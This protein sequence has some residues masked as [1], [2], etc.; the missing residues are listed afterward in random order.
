[1]QQSTRKAAQG[2]ALSRLPEVSS[3]HGGSMPVRRANPPAA[4]RRSL[5][6]VHRR[7]P[8]A[9]DILSCATGVAYGFLL[10]NQP[11]ARRLVA[12]ISA[13][14]RRRAG[15]LATVRWK[16]WAFAR[17]Q[18]NVRRRPQRRCGM[19]VECGHIL[20]RLRRFPSQKNI[21]NFFKKSRDSSLLKL[22][23]TVR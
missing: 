22:P 6:F 7:N 13:A 4:K 10:R 18:A 5:F 21:L 16:I 11:P 9:G 19:V 12:R 17:I 1:M 2:T 14:E 3:S 15:N 23:I 20:S 8:V